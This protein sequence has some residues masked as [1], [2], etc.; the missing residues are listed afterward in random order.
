MKNYLK[1]IT[2]VSSLLVAPLLFTVPVLAVAPDG[3]GPW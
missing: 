2:I 3:L 1:K